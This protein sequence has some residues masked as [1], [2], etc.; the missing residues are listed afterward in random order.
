M[1]SPARSSNGSGSSKSALSSGASS[2]TD[3]E[4]SAEPMPTGNDSRRAIL[5]PSLIRRLFPMP[6]APSISRTAPE[7]ER[8]RASCSPNTASSASRPRIVGLNADGAATGELH[9]SPRLEPRLAPGLRERVSHQRADPRLVLLQRGGR[10]SPV[11]RSLFA[12]RSLVR[13]MCRRPARRTLQ[14]HDEL[15]SRNVNDES[16]Q[17]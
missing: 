13:A 9:P 11:A 15:G 6:A 2:A 8:T 16:K 10:T 1:L 14:T 5:M 17:P 12:T 4:G 3:S 7:P